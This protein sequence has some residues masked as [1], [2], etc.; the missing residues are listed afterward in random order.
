MNK[1]L[2]E[3]RKALGMTLAEFG[4]KLGVTAQSI[5]AMEKG[6]RPILDRTV[7]GILAAFPQV[8]EAWL[9]DGEGGMYRKTDDSDLEAALAEL[10]L[11]DV[12][13]RY[14]RVYNSMSPE[15]QQALD[16]HMR[17]FLADLLSGVARTGSAGI[18]GAVKSYDEMTAEEKIQAYRE[19]VLAQEKTESGA[20]P[21]SESGAG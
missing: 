6:I 12:C 15:I 5:S 19:D 2:F 20:S 1:R 3:L 16:E 10:R 8:S 11:P 21:L 4:E 9:R 17:A 13:A 7:I 14:V 18:V